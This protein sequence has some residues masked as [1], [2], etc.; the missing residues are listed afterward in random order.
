MRLERG[1]LVSGG[2]A[3]QADEWQRGDGVTWHSPYFEL[4]LTGSVA[5]IMGAE[6]VLS[7]RTLATPYALFI[8]LGVLMAIG[9]GSLWARKHPERGWS[10]Q[11]VFVTIFAL[12]LAAAVAVVIVANLLPAVSDGVALIIAGAILLSVVI[13]AVRDEKRMT[14]V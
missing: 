11:M 12:V 2:D 5:L 1:T 13:W 4:V 8:L 9:D 6:C 10:R 14:A 7:G 3:H